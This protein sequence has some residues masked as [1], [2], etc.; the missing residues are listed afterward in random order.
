MAYEAECATLTC[1]LA[2]GDLPTALEC[3]RQAVAFLETALS[4][5]PSHPLLAL[6]RFTLSD[7]ELACANHT[8]DDDAQKSTAAPEGDDD[9][10]A[11]A[12]CAVCLDKGGRGEVQGEVKGGASAL[13]VCEQERGAV[14]K[15]VGRRLWKPCAH[16]RRRSDQQLDAWL[17]PNDRKG[18]FRI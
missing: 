10:T 7:L 5:V 17:A 2:V 16:V 3:C 18:G 13:S 12:L 14:Q 1:A 6:Q 4:H 15:M 11:D 9:G 8:S